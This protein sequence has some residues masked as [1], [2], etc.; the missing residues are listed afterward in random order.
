[1]KNARNTQKSE[2]SVA[3]EAAPIFAPGALPAKTHTVTAEVL[4]HLLAHK[5]LT[6]LETVF[7]AGTTRLAAVVDYLQ[8]H[9]GWS[10][11][12]EDKA[13][14]C[15]DGR[16]AYVSEYWIPP[17]TVAASMAAG[18]GEWCCNVRIA[19]RQLRAKAA[20][21]ARTAAQ[22]NAARSRNQPSAGQFGLF[23]EVHHG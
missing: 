1:M 16:V 9:Y 20:Q 8:K 12:R 2:A 23:E 14:G 18:A 15:K 3:V 11:S 10:I 13:T 5:R 19:R 17:E 4:A 21:A 22:L 7:D 6:G